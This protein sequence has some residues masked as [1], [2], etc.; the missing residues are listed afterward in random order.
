MRR[1]LLFVFLSHHRNRNIL[2]PPI[3][4]L[5]YSSS[6]APA[7]RCVRRSRAPLPRA[8]SRLRPPHRI[9]HRHRLA[10]SHPAGLQSRLVHSSD[11]VLHAD[12]QRRHRGRLRTHAAPVLRRRDARGLRS[13]G[14]RTLIASKVVPI[15]TP[16]AGVSGT[17]II[18]LVP[19]AQPA[20]PKERIVRA[21]GYLL[22]ITPDTKLNLAAPL[23]SLAEVST[24]QWIQYSGMQQ[25][26]G[27]VTVHSA[28][29]TPNT[30]SGTEDKLRN[31]TDYDPSK[32]PDDAHQSNF[33]KAFIGIDP[34]RIPPYRDDA[35]QARVE[36]IG[37]SLVPAYQR[38]LP[39]GDPA[40]INFRFQV[41]DLKYLRDAVNMP[42][43]VIVIPFQI[44]E[45]MQNDYQLAT[46][47]ADNIAENLEKDAL[48][49]R[50]LAIGSTAGTVAQLA[51]MT[52]P[53]V[54]LA[55]TLGSIGLDGSAAHVVSLQLAQS[56]RVSLCLLHDAGYNI[57]QAPL[58]WWLLAGKPGKPIDHVD[59]PPRAATLY[60]MLGTT[61]HSSAVTNPAPRTAS[62]A[63]DTA[64]SAEN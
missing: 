64:P 59:V 50:P 49:I 7:S 3:P 55:T 29:I 46:V 19:S 61:W 20:N 38:A 33:S 4:V 58:A 47:L 6:H 62:A 21:D 25:A 23:K 63:N 45:R 8:R 17:A 12:T 51:T 5:Y 2:F 13:H 28:S 27:T 18:D 43:G 39:D 31:K 42:S 14:C 26:D 41:I 22:R 16:P 36:R 40:K 34:K 10:L 60:T 11:A 15:N 30:V 52:V 56:G 57:E 48:R 44:V 1:N 24:N 32:V 54:G 35:M 53:F 9:R 37:Q